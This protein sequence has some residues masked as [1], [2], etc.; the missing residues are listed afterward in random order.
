M[1]FISSTTSTTI[2]QDLQGLYRNNYEH[3][4]HTYGEEEVRHEEGDDDYDN[5]SK[6]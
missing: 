2:D 3:W 4:N 5:V 6:H 1:E